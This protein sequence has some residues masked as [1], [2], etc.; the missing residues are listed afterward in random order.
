MPQ[1]SSSQLF[2]Y[3]PYVFLMLVD[4]S[5]GIGL[6][7][8]MDIIGLGEEALPQSVADLLVSKV[9]NIICHFGSVECRFL[10]SSHCPY[11][12]G[13]SWQCLHLPSDS[14]F[15]R[16]EDQSDGSGLFQLV[17]LEGTIASSL[18]LIKDVSIFGAGRQVPGALIIASKS[19]VGWKRRRKRMRSGPP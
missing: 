3:I 5:A 1:C 10:L 12:S 17:I 14:P 8:D 18:A 4:D 11:E 16:F 6:L 2:S 19:G 7:P 15:L 13:K 9:V